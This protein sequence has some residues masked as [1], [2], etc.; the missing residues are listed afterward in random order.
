M[1][2]FGGVVDDFEQIVFVTF[3]RRFA[4]ARQLDAHARRD[5]LD[6]FRKCEALGEGEEFENV[7][8][9]AA[10]ETVE[11]SLVTIDVERRRFLAN[12]R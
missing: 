3:L 7:T 8:A 1:K 12:S 2:G 9:G 11:E 5:M 10:A 4:S 6:S